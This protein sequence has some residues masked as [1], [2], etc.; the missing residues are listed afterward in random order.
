M[1]F[2]FSERL[3]KL[4]PY[5]FA[6]LDKEKKAKPNNKLIDLGIGDPDIPTPQK[7]IEKI[8]YYFDDP[9][10]H[11]Y[12]NYEGIL[13]LRTEIANYY[14]KRFNVTLDPEK[15]ILVLIGSKEGIAHFPMAICN[16]NTAVLYPSPGYPVY[17]S[18]ILLA[19]GNPLALPLRRENDF[20][21]CPD[22]LEKIIKLH[23]PSCIILNFPSNPT[24][25]T[26]PKKLIHDI[27]KLA[28][29]YN[30]FIAYDNAYSE[31]YF[32]DRPISILEINDAKKIAIEF[33]SFSKTFN[34]TGMRLGYAV[35]NKELIHSLT[36]VKKNIDSGPLLAIQKA[37]IFCLNHWKEFSDS[38]RKVYLKRRNAFLNELGNIDY[39]FPKATFF[40]WAKVP[41]GFSSMTFCK[42]LI[43]KKN[44]IVTPG[45]GFGE[46]GEGYFRISL[47]NS[48]ETLI[49][50][51]KRIKE[52]Y[53]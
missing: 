30:V 36:Q 7:I 31:I 2:D 25:I 45:V 3:K 11:K 32:E 37:G 8:K 14:R 28:I 23:S 34:M 20:L 44:V 49:N 19:D 50:G 42:E 35:G 9:I 6:E 5:I 17:L 22:E 52:L 48:V 10:N 40:V 1:K 33:G 15:E 21:P 39:V 4:P 46:F 41:N 16:K 51:A 12:S 24:T 13:E 38:I 29:K 27:V 53:E 43:R 47:T 18:S 26:C